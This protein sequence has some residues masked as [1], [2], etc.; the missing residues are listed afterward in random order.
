MKTWRQGAV[1]I[2]ALRNSVRLY[3]KCLKYPLAVFYDNEPKEDDTEQKIRFSAFI[4]LSVFPSIERI[5]S[6]KLTKLEKLI[7]GCIALD[8]ASGSIALDPDKIKTEILDRYRFPPLELIDLARIQD[9]Y[10]E[11]ED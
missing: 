1:G 10:S 4:R 11:N 3:L 9:L 7:N 2:I 6:V 8:F 5:G